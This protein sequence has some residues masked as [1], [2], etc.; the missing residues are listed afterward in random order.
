MTSAAYTRTYA[1]P[2]DLGH[3]QGATLQYFVTVAA[4]IRDSDVHT[5]NTPAL[6]DADEVALDAAA[7]AGTPPEEFAASVIAARRALRLAS[8]VATEP[9]MV[10]AH[11]NPEVARDRTVQQ[12]AQLLAGRAYGEPEPCASPCPQFPCDCPT[13]YMHDV[14][15]TCAR[16]G[17]DGVTTLCSLTADALIWTDD[18]GSNGPE[19]MRYRVPLVGGAEETLV[20]VSPGFGR[21]AG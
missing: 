3:W 16:C 14:G 2:F 11:A 15:T 17:V 6:T 1:E 8:A 9:R 10:E 13:A 18:Y 12:I 20:G 5:T 21:A 7:R 19:G 4:L